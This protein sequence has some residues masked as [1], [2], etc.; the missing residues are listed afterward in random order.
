M[1]T[2]MLLAIVLPAAACAAQQADLPQPGKGQA[3]FAN[4]PAEYQQAV[5]SA[6]EWCRETYD[7]GARYLSRRQ[8]AANSVVIFGCM[9]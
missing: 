7:T 1:R 6:E 4:N 2:L 3:Y 5:Q 8:E 9:N